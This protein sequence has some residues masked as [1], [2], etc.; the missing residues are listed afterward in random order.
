MLGVSKCWS[1]ESQSTSKQVLI[2]MVRVL[3]TICMTH[4]GGQSESDA[5]SAADLD[6]LCQT[7]GRLAK[8]RS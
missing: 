7:M 8:T 4:F 1:S 3:V 6:W 5:K 2:R